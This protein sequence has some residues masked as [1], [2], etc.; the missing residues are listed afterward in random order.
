MRTGSPG[1][2]G[3][4]LRE[5]REV[6]QLT[7]IGLAELVGSTSSAISSYEKGTYHTQSSDARPTE[8]LLEL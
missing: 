8:F 1:F 4:R 7:A 5:A 2:V 3:C 6:R